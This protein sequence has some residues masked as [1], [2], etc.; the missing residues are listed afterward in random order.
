MTIAIER[1]VIDDVRYH[2]GCL[3]EQGELLAGCA[4]AAGLDA[5]VPTCPGWRVR[6]LLRHIGFVHRWAAGYVA[7][8]RSGHDG[9]NGTA[10]WLIRL[11]PEQAGVS[12]GRGRAD[13]DISGRSSDLYLMLRNRTGTTGLEVAGD[14]AALAAWTA[15][16]RVT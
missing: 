11:G 6:D 2:I 12:R 3:Q 1:T 9:A 14:T 16:F 13:C 8:Q 15:Q 7:G 5:L 4:A 10:Q